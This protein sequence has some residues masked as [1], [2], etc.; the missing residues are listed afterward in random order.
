MSSSPGFVFFTTTTI[1]GVGTP[2]PST[3]GLIV[4]IHSFGP[5][6]TTTSFPPSPVV[7][8]GNHSF[9]P[10]SLAKSDQTSPPASIYPHRSLSLP[11][12]LRP[13]AGVIFIGVASD[14]ERRRKEGEGDKDEEADIDGKWS[15][16]G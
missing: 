7:R 11:Y 6:S 2:P 8:F 13:I 14:G 3:Y 16:K 5:P 10:P 12:L 9:R 4:E 1:S 15:S